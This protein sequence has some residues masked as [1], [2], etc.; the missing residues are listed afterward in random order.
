M[1]DDRATR[2]DASGMVD[3]GRA[4]GGAGLGS[5]NG[6][7]AENQ[8]AQSNVFHRSLLECDI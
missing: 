4:S 8:Q 3:A 2:P 5:L 1:R 6:E 7:R